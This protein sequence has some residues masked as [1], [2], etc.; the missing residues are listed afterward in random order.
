M[1]KFV[2]SDHSPAA[3]AAGC[4]AF[5][6]MLLAVLIAMP[7][8]AAT[9]TLKA[10]DASGVSAFT[11]NAPGTNWVY[12]GTPDTFTNYFSGAYGLRTP[13]DTNSY[14]FSGSSLTLQSPTTTG[15]SFLEKGATNVT[16]TINNFTNAGGI[17]RSGGGRTL[18]QTIAG[19]IFAISANSAIWADQNGWI[20]NSPLSGSGILTNRTDGIANDTIAYGGNNSAWTGKMVINSSAGT[21]V[22]ILNNVNALPGNPASFTPDQ[23][24][25]GGTTGC[26]LVDNA[27]VSANNVNGGV[28]LAAATTITNATGITTLISEPITGGSAL[29]MNGV[30][31]LTLSGS[32]SFTGGLTINNAGQL[33]INRTNALGTG[34]FNINNAN[35]VI[36]NTSGGAIPIL[37]CAAGS[38]G[39]SQNINHQPKETN[40]CSHI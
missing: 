36:D 29:T 20:I 2:K 23:I 28:T 13:A 1:S 17:I 5:I 21:A 38:Q 16:Y 11:N 40:E 30:G 33:N 10:A 15:Y 3:R 14:T 4:F 12:V 27:G 31:T 25:L 26:L 18:K 32:N 37:N 19:N 6:I 24:N 8:Q 7:A 39:S 35:A 9:A 22:V 34:T